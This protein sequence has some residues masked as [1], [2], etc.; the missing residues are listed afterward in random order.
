MSIIMHR[1]FV[2]NLRLKNLIDIINSKMWTKKI[3]IRVR[4]TAAY[5]E[6]MP[7]GL[8][9]CIKIVFKSSEIVKMMKGFNRSNTNLTIQFLNRFLL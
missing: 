3:V 9:T 2:N 8:L 1:L 7:T 4:F 5:L 6:E